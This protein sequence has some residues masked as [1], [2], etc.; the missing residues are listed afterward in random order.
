MYTMKHPQNENISYALSRMIALKEKIKA[1]R[2][3]QNSDWTP[4]RANVVLDLAPPDFVNYAFED[5]TTPHQRI[6]LVM[7]KRAPYNAD[8]HS[9]DFNDVKL[10]VELGD[11]T[12]IVPPKH[13]DKLAEVVYEILGDMDE[14]LKNDANGFKTKVMSELSKLDV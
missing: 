12:F 8:E 3:T 9:Y 4:F 11:T 1:I 7:N 14:C 10:E 2:S 13:V 6:H 5:P